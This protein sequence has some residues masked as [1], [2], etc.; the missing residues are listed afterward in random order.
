MKSGNREKD[1]HPLTGASKLSY[2][3]SG[4]S[5]IQEQGRGAVGENGTHFPRAALLLESREPLQSGAAEGGFSPSSHD[6]PSFPHPGL[7]LEPHRPSLVS[8]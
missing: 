3:I 8:L 6:P 1:G 4:L 7:W 5:S 2:S